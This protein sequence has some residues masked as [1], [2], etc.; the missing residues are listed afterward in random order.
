MLRAFNIFHHLNSLYDSFFSYDLEYC[1]TVF[2]SI[3][4]M[5][6][7]KKCKQICGWARIL[8][9][10]SLCCYLFILKV[11]FKGHNQTEQKLH[12]FPIFSKL[13]VSGV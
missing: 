11:K 10:F 4:K 3:Q 8:L 7:K 1:L 9:I 13:A 5:L 12:F 6:L 2:I